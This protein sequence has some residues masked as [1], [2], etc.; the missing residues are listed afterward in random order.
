MTR[1][2]GTP[3]APAPS[4]TAA[5]YLALWR[6][7]EA[8]AASN[9]TDALGG[10]TLTHSASP[11]VLDPL[12]GTSAS[13]P[14]YGARDFNGSTQYG[15][16]AASDSDESFFQAGAWAVAA[17]VRIDAFGGVV[18]EYGEYGVGTSATNTQMQIRITNTGALQMRWEYGTW[19]TVTV[20]T[21][22]MF[23]TGGTYH[24]G[25]ACEPD[26]NTH[27]RL[28]L[29][30]Y[31]NGECVKMQ[32]NLAPPSGG[33]SAR[34]IAGA[35]FRD[36]SGSGVAGLFFDGG[37]D[38]IVIAAWSP[39]HEWFRS[40]YACGVR[41]FLM[42]VGVDDGPSSSIVQHEVYARVLVE[43]GEDQFPLLA[44]SKVNLTDLDL[45]NIEGIDFLKSAEWGE[46]IDDADAHARVAFLP[47]HSTWNLSPFVDATGG[48]AANPLAGLFSVRRRI[49]IEV[50]T[51]PIGTGRDGVGPHWW[52][53]FD[54]WALSVDVAAD[55]VTL[56]LSGALAPLQG[57]WVEPSATAGADRSYGSSGGQ[58]VETAAQ[59]AIEEMDPARFD[60][61]RIDDDG[62][63]NTLTI[64]VLDTSLEK[65]AGRPHP[66]IAGDIVRV[67]GTA[68]YDGLW[69]VH[70]ATTA[71]VIYTVEATGGGVAAE[72]AGVAWAVQALGY[73][74][75][76]P[77]IWC[78]TS[79][80]WNI[81]TRNEPP[82]KSVA[83][84][85]EDWIEEI[86]WRAVYRFDQ[87]RQEFRLKV[88]DPRAV[89]GSTN[90][91]AD[92][93]YPPSR[94]AM[95]HEDQR[96][97]GVLLYAADSSKDPHGERLPYAVTGKA[98]GQLRGDGRYFFHIS[99]GDRSLITSS[100]EAQLALDTVLG[101]LQAASAEI[102][103]VM[104][105]DPRVELHDELQ[106]TNEDSTAHQL[107]MSFGRSVYS[108][109]SKVEHRM[110]G[111]ELRT[112]VATRKASDATVTSSIARG[113][114]HL[115]RFHAQ[116]SVYGQ[117]L[118]PVATPAAPTLTDLGTVNGNKI[119]VVS[120]AMP[121]GDAQRAWTR[122]EVHMSTSSSTFTPSSSTLKPVVN[123][124][125]AVI[126]HSFSGTTY[127]RIVHLDDPG[128][129]SAPSTAASFSA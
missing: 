65:G 109:A 61:L 101:D 106:V 56:S 93:I 74:G 116:G 121:S 68:G 64:R 14:G 3:F 28:R 126:P 90:Y 89:F 59:N 11:G 18:L 36:G 104:P 49:K 88:Y 125:V 24:I 96:T 80:S 75:G 63:A 26:P 27:N 60:I 10:R 5:D 7:G 123:A 8:S 13:A 12:F 102:E 99:V 30:F 81:F 41:D 119:L 114:R 22:I 108:V 103:V 97:V 17:W 1:Y 4:S 79:P 122:T 6:C 50:A 105:F 77:S 73:K 129:R 69:T 107:A 29:R 83:Q 45:T 71:Q 113:R 94:I 15:Y 47:R 2:L 67:A 40:L 34:W 31:V 23:A 37:I 72:T 82:S 124:T 70:S 95:H 35:S 110:S 127:V 39:R 85:L 46:D 112:T 78:P 66:F 52:L 21:S 51:V 92:T 33:S 38:D 32:G 25:I 42:R 76:K 44:E 43:V 53:M 84:L 55:A 58:A 91:T 87:V 117:G 57:A 115:E 9:L 48:T 100:T 20:A 62:G 19:T 54:G 128:N 98:L 111:H 120:W 16:R 118:S 86:G